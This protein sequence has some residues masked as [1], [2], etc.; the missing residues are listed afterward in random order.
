MVFHKLPFGETFNVLL[1]VVFVC[2]L[3]AIPMMSKSGKGYDSMAEKLE[4]QRR[5]KEEQ[6]ALEALAK[7]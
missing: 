1:G 4:A 7:K 3:G 2:G 6:E 5:E